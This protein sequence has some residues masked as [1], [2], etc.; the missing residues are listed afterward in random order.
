MSQSQRYEAAHWNT[1]LVDKAQPIMVPPPPTPAASKAELRTVK[2]HLGKLTDAK[3]QVVKYWDAG[4]PAYRWNQLV[5]KLTAQKF[6]VALRMPSAWMNMAIYDATVLAWREKAKH[7]RKR[8]HQVDPSL[9]P[10]IPAPLT[11]SYP[12]EHSVTAAAAAHVLAYFFPAKADSIL[13]MGRAAAQSRI[14]AGVQFPSDVEAGWKLGEQVARQIIEKAKQDGSAMVWKGDINKD[15]KKWTGKYPL[16]INLVSYVPLVLKSA[17]Q[18]QPP[19]PPDF[20]ADMK[21]MKEFKQTFKTAAAAYFWAN[22]GDTWTDL[23]SQKMFEYRL[24]EDAPAAARIYCVLSTAYHDAAIAIMDAKYAYWGIRPSQYDSTYKPLISTPPFPGYPSGH[25]AAAAT[26]CEV[27]S[28]FFP[29]DAEQFRKLAKDCADSRFYA[30][31]HFRTDN[32][33]G[34]TMGRELGRYVVEFLMKKGSRS[35]L[36]R[37]R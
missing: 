1:W 20:A 4:A 11:F 32:E 24:H 12:C 6:E 28:Y 7:Q 35:G 37:T 5:P 23:A 9:K 8:P 13:Q 27:L 22:S 16:G 33:V 29:A 30:G 21:E 15:P 17:N 14:D 26:S 19:A 25:A 31:I 36:S 34:L 18:F 10:A 2:Q 3:L